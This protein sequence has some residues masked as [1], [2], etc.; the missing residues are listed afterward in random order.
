MSATASAH[1]GTGASKRRPIES[2]RLRAYFVAVGA[3]VVTVLAFGVIREWP[4]LQSHLPTMLLWIGVAA[5]GDLMPVRLWGTV[6]LSMSLPVTLAAGMI[7]SPVES[8][9][10]AF[11]AAL[12]MRE[13]RSEISVARGLYNRGLVAASV[14][15]ASFFFHLVG[16]DVAMW[17]SVLL[18]GTGA[19]FVDWGVNTLLV[20]VPVAYGSGL[21]PSQVLG[22]IY[23]RQPGK[24]LVSYVC[25]G[26]LAALLATL[27]VVA[28][29]WGLIACLA[30]LGLARQLFS[31]SRQL[32]AASASLKEKDRAL[33]L[34]A[35]LVLDE[36]R[37][38][39]MAVAGEL[40]D[41]VLPP[42][43]KVHL[44]GQV[45]RQDL[46][47]G[48]LLAL[49]EDI[50][51]LI[52]AT[53]AAQEAIRCV[54]RDLRRSS[55]GP[56]G[57]NSTLELL[58]ETLSNSGCPKIQ[59]DLEDVGGSSVV[60]LLAYQIAREALN[61]AARHSK[62][63]EIKLSLSRQGDFVRLVVE[64]DGVGF[65]A[66]E[67]NQETHFGLQLIRERAES[68]GGSAYIDSALGT[69]TVVSVLLPAD[70]L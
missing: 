65:V 7:F 44:M 22:Q 12:D 25:L 24:H 62:A 4:S 1:I 17:P 6:T 31:Q 14:L 40:H 27:W 50:P 37:D 19:L 49:D 15:T 43:F 70:I 35:D 47:A 29:A 10:I 26:F 67:I 8:G 21:A 41:E 2:T 54:V 20:I 11:L 52:A 16:G 36:R 23:G 53:E 33:V 28:G 58:C 61:N 32:D 13:F 48:R 30:P 69:G 64:D 5:I 55:L 63:T 51:E 66:F 3:C 9:L 60:Q 59:L 45:L 42:L 56:G 39:R 38:E 34:S 18:L 57:L 68:A 46:K